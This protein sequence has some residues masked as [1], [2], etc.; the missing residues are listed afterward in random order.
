VR[1]LPGTLRP[2]DRGQGGPTLWRRA[3]VTGRHFTHSW[4]H[5]YATSL[6]RRGVDIHVVQRLLGHSN[7]STTV[8]YLHLSDADLSEAVERAFSAD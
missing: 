2:D 7:I 5:A 1:P 8:R 4:R 3:E 6:L